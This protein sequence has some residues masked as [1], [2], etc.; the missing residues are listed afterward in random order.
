MK[1]CT[2]STATDVGFV[3]LYYFQQKVRKKKKWFDE[4][5]NIRRNTTQLDVCAKARWVEVARL[6]HAVAVVG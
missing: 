5:I 2:R 4:R 6:E 1:I 3:V